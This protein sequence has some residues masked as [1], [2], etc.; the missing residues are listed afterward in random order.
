[1]KLDFKSKMAEIEKTA[2]PKVMSGRYDGIKVTVDNLMTEDRSL[3][4]EHEFPYKEV[5]A[6]EK[7]VNE[8]STQ[9][10]NIE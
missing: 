5:K 9:L 2:K 8:G 3:E 6:V 1:M 4:K 7:L 10:N